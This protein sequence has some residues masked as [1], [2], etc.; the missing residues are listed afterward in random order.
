MHPKLLVPLVVASLLSSA[1]AADITVTANPPRVCLDPR[2][3]SYLNVDFII[4]NGTEK[5]AKLKELRGMVLAP[6]GQLLERRTVSQGALDIV[7]PNKVYPAG[8]DGLVYNVLHFSSVR[9]GVRVRFEFDFDADAAPTASVEIVPQSCVSRTRLVAP[10]AGRI[11][12]MDG[13]D[14][15]SHHRRSYYIGPG[16]RKVGITDNVGRF[17]LD[18]AVIGANG[19]RFTGDRAR[20]ES[21]LTWDKPVRAA[22]AGIVAATWNEQPDNDVI[23]SENLWVNRSLA[24][25]EMSSS[26]NYVLIDHGNGE[27]SLV[28][29]LRRGSVRVKKGDRVAAGDIVAHAGNSGSSLGPHVHYELRTGWGV[30]DIHSMPPYFHDLRIVGTGETAGAKGIAVNTGDILMTR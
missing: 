20:N 10:L 30:R 28:A 29:H 5:D 24:E 12:V 11:A 7:A 4:H 25:N 22:G 18:L 14:F 1:M 27:F 23:G 17:G 21:W 19:E 13:F 2:Q 9:D 26:G 15:L 16:A 6:N 3:P 8:G